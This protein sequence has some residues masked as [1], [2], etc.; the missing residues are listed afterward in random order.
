MAWRPPPANLRSTQR[1]IK[2]RPAAM[3]K[4]HAADAATASTAAMEARLER[5]ALARRS[6]APCVAPALRRL[7]VAA[8]ALVALDRSG[9]RPAPAAAAGA[10]AARHRHDRGRPYPSSIGVRQVAAR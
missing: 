7:L 4:A 8:A 9:A 10:R 5:R 1:T 6:L 2:A 3:A